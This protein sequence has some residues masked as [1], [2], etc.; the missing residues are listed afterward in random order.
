MLIMD[1]HNPK[2]RGLH[3][4]AELVEFYCYGDDVIFAI[5]ESI[6]DIFNN[7]TISAAFAQYNFKYTDVTKDDGMRKWCT[8]EEATFLKRGFKLFKQTSVP[9]GMWICLPDLGDVLDTTNWVRLPKSKNNPDRT[10]IDAAIENCE[11]CIRKSWFHG[12]EQF[13]AIQEKIRIFFKERNLRQ[14]RHYT[15]Y[16]LQADYDIPL[17]YGM[18]APDDI[19][20]PERFQSCYCRSNPEKDGNVVS[21]CFC[22]ENATPMSQYGRVTVR[23]VDS[24]EF[25]LAPTSLPTRCVTTV[26]TG[27]AHEVHPPSPDVPTSYFASENAAETASVTWVRAP[28][29]VS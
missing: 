10:V 28:Q 2:L 26:E 22:K 15:Y 20:D 12:R 4:F 24:S 1:K 18:S 5:D 29:K 8:L 23:R 19:D 11:D 25:A 9:G 6:K 3:H 16:G 17:P 13:E 14:P 27:L 7:E 21:E